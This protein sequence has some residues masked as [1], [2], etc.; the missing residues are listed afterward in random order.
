MSNEALHTCLSRLG[1]RVFCLS[2]RTRL[3][4]R[5]CPLWVSCG[6]ES[7][8]SCEQNTP[9]PKTFCRP[10]SWQ[11]GP[12]TDFGCSHFLPGTSST[13]CFPTRMDPETRRQMPETH[14]LSNHVCFCGNASGLYT[15]SF[16]TLLADMMIT[17]VVELLEFR[18]WI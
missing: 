5:L 18:L 17:P 14:Y 15:F 16:D 13:A 6:A 7:Q 8:P 11:I 12:C 9:R 3:S 10:C 4:W 1:S 2:L